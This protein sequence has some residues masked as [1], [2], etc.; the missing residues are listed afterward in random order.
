[1]KVAAIVAGVLVALL[2]GACAETREESGQPDKSGG[3]GEADRGDG[4]GAGGSEGDVRSRHPL[5][6]VTRVIDGD[7]VET[8]KEGRVRL[9]GADT[10]EERRCQSTAATSFTRQRLEGETVGY[11]LG[12]ERKDRYGRTLAYLYRDENMHNLD[13]VRRGYAR[14][15]TIPPNDKYEGRFRRVAQRARQTNVGV[16]GIC[17]QRIRGAQARRRAGG[18]RARR[19]LARERARAVRQHRGTGDRNR[20]SPSPAPHPPSG[21]GVG[22]CLPSSACPGK[23]DGDGDGCYCE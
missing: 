11:E 10:P 23:R 18:V 21:S 15:L 4:R 17:E 9:I 5:L 22:K 13:L 20:P 7:T 1:M 2:I 12:V 8:D 16:W 19:R 6:R 3:G 14:V